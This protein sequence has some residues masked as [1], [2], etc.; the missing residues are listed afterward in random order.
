MAGRG[1]TGFRVTWTIVFIAMLSTGKPAQALPTGD[2]PCTCSSAPALRS[3]TYQVDDS[4]H[5]NHVVRLKDGRVLV[6]R[7]EYD[8]ETDSYLV[9]TERGIERILRRDVQVIE[10][11]S[12]TFLPPYYNPTAPILPCDTRQRE[13]QWYFAEVRGWLYATREDQSQSQIGLE[14]ITIGPEIAAGFRIGKHFGIGLGVSYF[15]ARDIGRTPFFLHGR[16]AFSLYCL[17]PFA[18]VQAGMVFDNQSGDNI[19][20]NKIFHPG[21]KIL[22]FGIGVDY[23][24]AS[25]IDFSADI[26]YRY[27]QLPTK[28]PCDCSD[29]P[30]QRTAI[31]YNES[32]GVLLR[33][34]VTF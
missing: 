5:Y 26:G 18:Y 22:G 1:A 20:L 2:E 16:Y 8:E 14:A 7:A 9:K 29:E 25:W 27:L 13:R 19:A 11:Y 28:V 23:P 15:N 30:P 32:H 6:G 4:L 34:G 17:S 21:P 12:R 24:L 33:I 31:Y 10:T 3:S